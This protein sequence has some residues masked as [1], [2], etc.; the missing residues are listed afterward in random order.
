MEC[1]GNDSNTGTGWRDV[2]AC[3]A[4]APPAFA[5]AADCRAWLDANSEQLCLVI[6]R[7]C[8]RGRLAGPDFEEF[9][10]ATL[11]KFV[12]RD[13]AV[14]RAFAGRS[15]L[16]TYLHSVVTRHLLDWRNA[17]WGKW[18]PSEYARRTGP[19]AVQ[20]ER[21][22]SR[23]GL[24]L[25]EAIRFMGGCARAEQARSAL[26]ALAPAAGRLRTEPRHRVK[27]VALEGIALYSHESPDRALVRED[28]VKEG[29]HVARSLR[30]VLTRLSPEERA[31]LKM[32]FVDGVPIRDMAARLGVH[33]RPFY[34]RFANLLSALRCQLEREALDVECVRA[35]V[36][37]HEMQLPP[38]LASC[39]PR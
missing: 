1:A 25:A 7:V 13:Y 2:S 36:G 9:R 29:R 19:W 4:G 8:R 17:R 20:L 11:L 5:A 23:D 37:H 28:L 3:A 21:L 27:E 15:S 18:R 16:S 6:A 30:A 38:L 35:L 14:L 33:P 10:A 39:S 26:A 31:L 34:R 24:T 32:R 22:T 12:E